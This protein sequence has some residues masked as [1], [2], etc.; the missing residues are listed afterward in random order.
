MR[1]EDIGR[2]S[3]EEKHDPA[4]AL[5]GSLAERT[6]EAGGLVRRPW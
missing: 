5:R 2:V 4:K 6:T 1:W 3:V